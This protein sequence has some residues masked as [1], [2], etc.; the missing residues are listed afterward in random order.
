MRAVPFLAL[1]LAATALPAN[2][3]TNPSF[4]GDINQLNADVLAAFNV[5][6]AQPTNYVE[7]LMNYR[8]FFKANLVV[9][10]GHN[11]D[12][13]TQ[14]GTVPVDEAI[15]FLQ[16]HAALK[17]L[18]PSEI[19]Q[20]AAADHV[21]DQSRSGRTG[22]FDA[23]GASPAD[24]VIRH[25]GGKAVAEVIAYGAVDAEDVIR[26]LIIDDGVADRGHRVVMFADHL[27]YAGVACGP[28][29]EFGTMCVIDMADTPDAV[30]GGPVRHVAVAAMD[31]TR[32]RR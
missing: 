1:V 8:G 13:E 5:A 19:L 26:Q 18:Q 25:G 12:V 30:M 14:E 22:H 21:A 20:K 2:A 17:M 11:I 24:R 32:P 6:R 31:D 4:T 10:P 9:I 27:R 16:T 23:D 7:T 28:H 29:P 15:E 3:A